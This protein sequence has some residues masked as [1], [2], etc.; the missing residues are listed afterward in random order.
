MN[1]LQKIQHL[2]LKGYVYYSDTGLIKSPRG[3]IIKSLS[4]FGYCIINFRHNKKSYVLRAH[5]FAWYFVYKEIVNEI[6]HINGIRHDNR[7]LNL[8]SVTSQQNKFNNTVAKGYSFYKRRNMFKARIKVNGVDIHIGYYHTEIEA[9]NAYLN[10]K[11][12]YH[13]IN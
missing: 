12:V 3:N 11:K 13:K 4:K 1:R 5:Q 2:I 6:D 8:R 9:R 10:A 7:I